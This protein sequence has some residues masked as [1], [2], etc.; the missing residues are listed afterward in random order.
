MPDKPAAKVDAKAEATTDD[1]RGKAV[2]LPGGE[3]RVDYIRRRFYDEKA[4]RSVITK[5]LC[6]KQGKKIAY[7]I[8]FAATKEKT[9]PVP[10]EKK[11]EE[12]KP[13]AG[14]AAAA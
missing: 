5:E 9:K 2:I 12:S 13:E 1:G 6:E 4:T 8:V 11:A 14:K 10:A 3:R 7:Q